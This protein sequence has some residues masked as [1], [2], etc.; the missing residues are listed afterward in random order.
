MIIDSVK[1]RR[2]GTI[3]INY[4]EGGKQYG[5]TLCMDAIGEAAR[6]NKRKWAYV[7]GILRNWSRDGRVPLKHNGKV[8]PAE[9]VA[10]VLP[11]Y[12][13]ES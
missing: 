11:D 1:K 3:T 12:G 13:E 7:Q 8:Q 4:T 9:A 5:L 2:S 6:Q 10:I